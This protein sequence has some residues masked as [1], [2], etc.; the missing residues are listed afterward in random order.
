MSA[1]DHDLDILYVVVLSIGAVNPSQT[2]MAYALRVG[3]HLA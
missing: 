1:A 2:A 3:D